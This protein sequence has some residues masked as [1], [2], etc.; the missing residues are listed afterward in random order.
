MEE[1]QG[2]MDEVPW[3]EAQSVS[4]PRVD[5][6]RLLGAVGGLWRQFVLRAA[7]GRCGASPGVAGRRSLGGA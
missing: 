6:H 4:C 1:S 3:R 7:R 5:G 2:Q